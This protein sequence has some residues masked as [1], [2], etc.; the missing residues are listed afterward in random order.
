MKILVLTNLYPPF[1][2][3]GYELSC[4]AISKELKKRN[5]DILIL[6]SSYGVNGEYKE[7]GIHR[8]LHFSTGYLFWKANNPFYM[9]RIIKKAYHSFIRGERCEKIFLLFIIM[10]FY[11]WFYW[12]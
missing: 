10:C 6:T 3:G 5:H 12:V 1:Y 11:D 9:T 2:V 7:Q 8:K 4:E